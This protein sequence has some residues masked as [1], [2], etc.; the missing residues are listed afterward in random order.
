MEGVEITNKQLHLILSFAANSE[1]KEKPPPARRTESPTTTTTATTTATTMRATAAGGRTLRRSSSSGRTTARTAGI[2]RP[3]KASNIIDRTVSG[4]ILGGCKAL[5]PRRTQRSCAPRASASAR[6]K[7]VGAKGL[8]TEGECPWVKGVRVLGCGSSAPS[9]VVTNVDLEKLVETNDEWIATRTGIRERR[10]LVEGETLSSHAAEAAMRAL[11]ASNVRPEEVDL[12]VLATSSADDLF[13]SAPMV[14]AAIGADNAAA[15]D[16]TSACSG[17][18][19]GL[20]TGAQYVRT[21]AYSKVLVVGGDALSRFVDWTD[22]NTCI[23]F[24]DGCGA[25]V[26]SAQD[27]AEFGCNLLSFHIESDGSLRKHLNAGYSG[28][29]DKTAEKVA[30]GRG[31]HG[32]YSNI[33]MSGQ[34]VFKWAVRAVPSAVKKSLD[35]SG[36]DVSEIDWLLLHQANTRILESASSRLGVPPEKV[37]S[38]ISQYG[39][40]SAGSIPLALD[41]AVKKGQIKKGDLIA[42]AGFGAGLTCASA[43]FLWD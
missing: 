26:L 23:L 25:C 5:G 2:A 20:I 33:Y 35:L 22:R 37:I 30:G 8:G 4:G 11:E 38:N 16:V 29:G 12:I 28:T 18:V 1:K 34:D 13:G 9:K 6:E 21:G 40:T 36:K 39:N 10:V 43:V 24:G 42:T 3:S 19:V 32:S 27:P 17:F 31:K 7:E 41:E 14:Q 15:F